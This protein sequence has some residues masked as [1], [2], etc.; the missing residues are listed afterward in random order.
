VAVWSKASA[1]GRS[2][3]AIAGS[4][5]VLDIDVSCECCVLSGRSLCDGPI[6]CPEESYRVWC[7]LVSEC[8]LE[9]STTGGL[10]LLGLS[11]HGKKLRVLIAKFKIKVWVAILAS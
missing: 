11:S 9:T 8:E 5:P 4:N 1:S 2:L 10:G 7:V 3:A 6:T